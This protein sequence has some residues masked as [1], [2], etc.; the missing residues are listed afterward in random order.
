[1]SGTSSVAAALDAIASCFEG[2]V[3]ATICSCAADGTPNVTYL[4]IV[5]RLG[6]WHV[7]LSYQFFNK[8]RKNVLENPMVQV[9]VV[10]TETADQ[11]RLDLQYERTEVE[12]PVFDRLSARLAAVASQTGMS[13]IFTLR[14]VDVYRVL[15][16]R[17]VNAEAQAETAPLRQ[18]LA[19]VESL[20]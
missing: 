7:G 16:C 18:Y 14:G 3:P 1:M 20:T 13:R 12:G 4:S 10:S 9:I 17:P 15:D 11:Y 19:H 6:E 8:T 2:I 5:H